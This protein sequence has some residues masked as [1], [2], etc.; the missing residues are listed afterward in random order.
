MRCTLR[1]LAALFA[2]AAILALTTPAPAQKPLD[3]P[4]LD[5]MQKDIFFLASPDCE[6]RGIETKGI[7]KAADYI[8]DAFKAA[9]VKPAMKDGTYFQPFKVPMSAK[10]GANNAFAI[11]GPDDK[12]IEP[13][14]G[15]DA[16]VMGF[17]ST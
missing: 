3:D 9:G 15:T 10:L 11:A 4:I 5:R 16:N 13:K 6:G 8:A 12:K 7:E 2:L 17:S 14:L 1:P